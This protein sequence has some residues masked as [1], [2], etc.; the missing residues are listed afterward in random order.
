MCENHDYCYVEM[1]KEDNKYNH[2][3]KTM[4]FLFIIYDNLES[5]LEKMKICYNNPKSF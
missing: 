1:A 5:L 4:K 3:E 2:A